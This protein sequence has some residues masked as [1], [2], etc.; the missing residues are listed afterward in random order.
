MT[1]HPGLWVS[2]FGV[3]LMMA[4]SLHLMG[5]G[6]ASG[7]DS[8]ASSGGGSTGGGTS[9]GGGSSGGA[10]GSGGS[11]SGGAPG[12][13]GSTSSGGGSGTAEARFSCLIGDGEYSICQAYAGDESAIEAI[14]DTEACENNGGTPGDGCS[15]EGAGTCAQQIGTLRYTSYYYGLTQDDVEV[16]TTLCDA[17]GGTFTPP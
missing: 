2:F 13:G 17:S 14:S 7:G 10:P 12:S 4:C 9:A 5:C 16:Y 8:S 15:P 3:P 1:G 6:G 11:T